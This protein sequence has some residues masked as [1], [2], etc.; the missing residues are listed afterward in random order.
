MGEAFVL[1]VRGQLK[2]RVTVQGKLRHELQ[3]YRKKRI[4]IHERRQNIVVA[5]RCMSYVDRWGGPPR[6]E[7][8]CTVRSG[9]E[10]RERKGMSA[11]KA[12]GR[13]V[14]ELGWKVTGVVGVACASEAVTILPLGDA[15]NL[16]CWIRGIV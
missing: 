3:T 13:I 12:R 15:A 10:V 5:E 11:G 6:C 9:R 1:V 2:I 8:G 4:G 14:D 16:R 7:R